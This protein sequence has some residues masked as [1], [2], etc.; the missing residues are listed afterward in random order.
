MDL[1][2]GKNNQALGSLAAN[3]ILKST[4]A[5]EDTITDQLNKYDE[6]MNNDVRSRLR[7]GHNM[8]LV[9][10][11]FFSNF[12]FVFVGCVGIIT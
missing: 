11:Y 7:Q 9:V 10:S 6:L 1:G 2:F 8:N 3:A 5:Q 4:Q 12:L